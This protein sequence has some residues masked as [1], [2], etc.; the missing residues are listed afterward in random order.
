MAMA[1]C[2]HADYLTE[3]A[4]IDVVLCCLIVYVRSLQVGKLRP[5][6]VFDPKVRFVLVTQNWPLFGIVSIHTP[7]L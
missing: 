6:E 1:S 4:P 5:G 3:Y 7:C 2:L